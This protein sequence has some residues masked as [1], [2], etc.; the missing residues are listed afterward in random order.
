MCSI[1]YIAKRSFGF[2]QCHLRLAISISSFSYYFLTFF[3]QWYPEVQHFCP[4]TPIVLVGL[5]ADLRKDRNATEVLRTQ[6]L[7]PVTYQ[8]VCQ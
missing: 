7:T 4:R 8:Q 5:K 1:I 6:G 3:F 2:L